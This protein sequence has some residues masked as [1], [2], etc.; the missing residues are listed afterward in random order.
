MGAVIASII[1]ALTNVSLI[2]NQ[3]AFLTAAVRELTKWSASP[4]MTYISSVYNMFAPLG[5]TLALCYSL[6][7]IIESMQRQGGLSNV[8]ADIILVPLLKFITCVLLIRYTP[9]LMSMIL[10]SSNNMVD[11]ITAVGDSLTVTVTESDIAHPVASGLVA[12]VAIE[13]IPSLISMLSQVIAFLI[14]S[15]QILTV[16]IEMMFRFVF[17]PFAIANIAHGGPGS[18][19]MRYTKRFIGTFVVMAGMVMAIKMTFLVCS[20]VTYTM[21]DPS[22]DWGSRIVSGIMGTLFTSAIGPFAAVGAVTTVRS[23]INEAFG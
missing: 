12:K 3:Y 1:A 22:I 14:V 19:G 4:L 11:A 18:A 23:M 9:D 8:T 10:G 7:E 16:R 2:G 15:I 21:L 13:L 17:M 20:G 6:M 5:M